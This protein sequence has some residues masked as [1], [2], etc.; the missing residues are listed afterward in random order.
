MQPTSEKSASLREGDAPAIKLRDSQKT[1]SQSR[2]SI[3]KDP[4]KLKEMAE[5]A[6]KNATDEITKQM[7]ERYEAERKILEQ[8]L[9][10]QQAGVD[11][12]QDQQI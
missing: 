3:T 10:E 2:L 5:L 6:I 4:A 1:E 9:K 12:A 11:E 7:A 8:K